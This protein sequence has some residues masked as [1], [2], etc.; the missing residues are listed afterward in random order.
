MNNHANPRRAITRTR[1]DEMTSSNHLGPNELV[2]G[3]L[4]DNPLADT[5]PFLLLNANSTGN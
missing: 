2:G 1:Y 5:F 4:P 3:A